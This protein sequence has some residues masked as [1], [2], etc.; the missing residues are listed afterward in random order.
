MSNISYATRFTVDATPQA[1]FDAVTNPKGWWAKDIEG[2]TAAK[3]DE[4]VQTYGDMHRCRIRVTEAVPGEK[5]SWY[6][7]EN[8]FSFTE[9]K[10][11]WTGTTITFDIK[12]NDDG[13]EVA[14]THEG[15]V[16][17]Y[18]CYDVCS[19]AWGSHINGSL[20]D[21]IVTG[22]GDPTRA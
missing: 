13:T 6:V 1:V 21:L 2:D 20:R 12:E 3:G 19:N 9:D 11:E 17:G 22:K 8:Y 15:L 7:L 18:E 5:V 16:T 4:F 14:F 10:T